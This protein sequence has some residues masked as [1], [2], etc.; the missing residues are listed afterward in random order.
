[1]M[2]LPIVQGLGGGKGKKKW[3]GGPMP[4]GGKKGKKGKGGPGEGV[5]VNLIVDPTMFG[6]GDQ[7]R[8]NRESDEDE[9]EEDGERRERPRQRKSIFAAVALEQDWKAARSAVKWSLAV[10]I[11]MALL[12]FAEFFFVLWSSR[13]SPGTFGGWYV[14][15]S[16]G[17]P[18]LSSL[19]HIF[20][21]V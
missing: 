20:V 10:D 8:R 2:V 3:K 11:F 15:S 9:D 19:I 18:D 17:C 5:Q 16:S 13:C 21:Q 4:P 1:M 12:W 6:G 14:R 7:S